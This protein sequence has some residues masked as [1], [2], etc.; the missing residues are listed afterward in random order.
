MIPTDWGQREHNL[1]LAPTF[2]HDLAAL[3]GPRPYS[4]NAPPDTMLLSVQP[5]GD[6][7]LPVDG[8]QHPGPRQHARAANGSHPAGYH[9]QRPGG[10][11]IYD[12]FNGGAVP[13]AMGKRRCTWPPAMGR[14]GCTCPPRPAP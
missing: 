14:A 8:Q 2:A 7:H 3:L 9:H 13:V 6:G 5:C 12:L 1:A 10:G 11:V 4:S